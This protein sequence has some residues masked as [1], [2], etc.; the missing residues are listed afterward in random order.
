M[1]PT[2]PERAHH[3]WKVIG[4][5]IVAAGLMVLMFAASALAG[6]QWA[7]GGVPLSTTDGNKNAEVVVPD[8]A[9]GAFT[10]WEED[11]D[12][13][14]YPGIF[15]QRLDASG[16]VLWT[17]QGVEVSAPDT[18][19]YD[20]VL[21]ADGQGGVI[22]LWND[23]RSQLYSVYGQRLNGAGKPYWASGG[24]VIDSDQLRH[25]YVTGGATD[26]AG[27]ALVGTYCEDMTVRVNRVSASGAVVWGPLEIAG[28]ASRPAPVVPAAGGC[29]I[30]WLEGTGGGNSQVFAQRVSVAATFQWTPGGIQVCPTTNNQA[31][32][33]MASDG[34]NGA[35]VAWSA[36]PPADGLGS[37]IPDQIYAQRISSAGARLWGGGVAPCSVMSEKYD[38]EIAGDSSG[39]AL[40]AW[41]DLRSTAEV[42]AQKISAAGK[43]MWNPG[44][45]SVY[46]GSSSS[47]DPEIITDGSGGAIVA[48]DVGRERLN[49]PAALGSG[50][51]A[52]PYLEE[53]HVYVQQVLASGQKSPGWAPQGVPVVPLSISDFNIW[54]VMATDGTGGAIVVFE[55]ERNGYYN[56][57][58]YAQRMKTTTATWYLAEGTTA[59]GFDTYLTV[60]NPNTTDSNV[61]I[62]YMLPGGKTKVKTLKLAAT[63]QTTFQPMDDLGFATDFSTKVESLS[64]Q[65][66]AVDRTMNWTGPGAPAGEAHSSIGVNS[67]SMSWFL[68]EGCTAYGFETW[69]LV[70]NPNAVDASCTF[71][72][73]IEGSAPKQVTKKVPANSRQS[74]NMADDIGQQSAATTIT[75]VVPVIAERS[76]YRN[77]RREGHE[78]IGATSASTD[79]YLAEGTTAWGFTTYVL[80]QNPSPNPCFVS[81][82]YMTPIGPKPMAPFTMPGYG[83]ATVKVN[84]QLPNTDFSTQVHSDQPIVAER[85]MYWTAQDASLGEAMHDTIGMT[86]PASLFYFPDGQS[87]DGRETFTLVQNPNDKDVVVTVTYMTPSGKGNVSFDQNIPATSR[88]TLNLKDKVPGGR[89]ATYIQV[90]TAGAKVMA[91]RAMY[92]NGRAAGTATIG[93]SS[94]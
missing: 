57:H 63:S 4:L 20:P 18:H 59:W 37:S 48:Y 32:P 19:S 83:R 26:S 80:V 16:N 68:P 43:V 13:S 25:V 49:A 21:V 24:V 9:G 88:V 64:G 12:W 67:P 73:M 60:Q 14:G 40:L 61:R 22:V 65:P 85:A 75:S 34:A 56:P 8:G 81:M 2:S 27:G 92:W 69:L 46:G 30:A 52:K 76:M 55:D 23:E 70:Q 91:E 7:P 82:T 47:F 74:F 72:Y 28:S 39:G 86:T 31:N 35:L 50:R 3:H 42:Y 58:V 17:A 79:Y 10:A 45:V 5:A 90:K 53:C 44:G 54:P 84:D 89:A 66:I 29:I 33:V 1:H 51:Y 36:Q 62:T 38:Y 93:G 71:T 15:A 11:R 94:D 87:S 78:S 6:A 77:N 41:T